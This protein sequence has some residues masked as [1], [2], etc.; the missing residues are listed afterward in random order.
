MCLIRTNTD[1]DNNQFIYFL[2]KL[3]LDIQQHS[4]VNT[5]NSSHHVHYHLVDIISLYRVVPVS[6]YIPM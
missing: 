1:R 2:N 3:S 5:E 6:I 4:P